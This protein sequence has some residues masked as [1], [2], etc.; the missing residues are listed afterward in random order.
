MNTFQTLWDLLRILFG[1]GA[2]MEA[3]PVGGTAHSTDVGIAPAWVTW[4]NGNR[5]AIS[6]HIER[7]K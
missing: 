1:A 3:M 5:F 2:I 6:L 7:V 4:R